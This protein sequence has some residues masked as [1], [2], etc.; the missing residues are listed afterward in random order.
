MRAIVRRW[1]ECQPTKEFTLWVGIGAIVAT[2]VFGFGLAGW[3]TAGTAKKMA[4]EAAATARNQLA[5]A[6]CVDQFMRAA[7]ARARL[8]KLQ[9]MNL[10]ER[11]DLVAAGGWAT[12][13]GEKEANGAVAEMCAARLAELPKA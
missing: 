6:V 12:M 3:L 11:D 9:A 1:T 5:A 8:A 4:D 10:W 13:P 2:L 7:D